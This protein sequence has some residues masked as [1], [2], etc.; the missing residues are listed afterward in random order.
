MT[1]NELSKTPVNSKTWLNISAFD[2]RVATV[3]NAAN[4]KYMDD[5][6]EGNYLEDFLQAHGGENARPIG[7]RAG[8]AHGKGP[9]V[10]FLTPA[11]LDEKAM[12]M[13]RAADQYTR[14]HG[15]PVAHD[16]KGIVDI[17]HV[18]N[19]PENGWRYIPGHGPA[20]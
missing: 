19:H 9:G 20:A 5:G 12:R 3:L 10:Y 15:W 11:D 8:N 13:F 2:Q 14:E 17:L 1:F 7:I 6:V 4:R 16:M 18:N